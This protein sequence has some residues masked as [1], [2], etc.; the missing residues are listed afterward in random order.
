MI[1]ARVYYAKSV[2]LLRHINV[3]SFD[4]GG[5]GIGKINGNYAAHR[6]GNLIHKSARFAEKYVLCVLRVL[7]DLNVIHRAVVIHMIEDISYHILK[8]RRGRKPRAFKD[9]GHRISVK[10]ADRMSVFRKGITHTRDKRRRRSEFRFIRRGILSKIYAVLGKALALYPNHRVLSCRCYGDYIKIDR[11]GDNTAVVM[12][13][14]ISRKLTSSRYREQGYL[15]L[16][17]VGSRKFIY[18]VKIASLLI[19]QRVRAI[20]RNELRVKRTV[21]YVNRHL[22]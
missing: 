14:V 1:S 16:L 9:V 21:I 15:P 2:S 5:C 17:T 18:R 6:T 12:V 22:L 7:R 19:S 11:R 10:S 20:K 4:N 13:G 8:R 3:K